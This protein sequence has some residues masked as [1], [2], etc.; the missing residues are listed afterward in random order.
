MVVTTRAKK[1]LLAAAAG[2]LLLFFWLLWPLDFFVRPDTP[3][4]PRLDWAE[5]QTFGE[6]A[7]ATAQQPLEVRFRPGQKHFS[8]FYLYLGRQQAQGGSLVLTVLDA[9]GRE[10]SAQRLE[11]AGLSLPAWQKIPVQGSYKA[12]EE[13]TLRISAGEGSPPIDL[14][15]VADALIPEETLS[16]S[17]PLRYAYD[18]PVFSTAD[19]LLL[20]LC[21][22]GLFGLFAAGLLGEFRG[23]GLLRGAAVFLLL[24]ALAAQNG[25]YGSLDEGNRP[26]FVGFQDNSEALVTGAIAASREPDCPEPG[27]WG[28]YTYNTVEP[29]RTDEEW[30]QGYAR[31]KPAIQLRFSGYT[32][33]VA[34]AGNRVRFANGAELMIEKAEENTQEELI[35]TLQAAGPLS[36]AEY[37][38]LRQAAFV[39]P[40]GEVYPAVS[41]SPYVSQYGLQGRVFVFLSRFIGV[42]N[43]HL[44]CCLALALVFSAI[45]FLIAQRYGPLLAGVF[46]L[47]FLLA[48]KVT[49][50]ARNLY[51]VEFTWFI[52]MAVG[53]F[54]LWKKENAGCRLLSYAAA[55]A[56][57][58]IKSLCGY[59]YLSTIMVA[60]VMFPLAELAVTLS[61][62]QKK[63]AARLFWGTFALGIM[64]LLGFAAALLIHA[65]YRGGGDLWTGVIN[66]YRQDVLRRTVGS[67]SLGLGGAAQASANVSAWQVL[68]MY[69]HVPQQLVT[70]ID[71]NLFPFVCT[72][73]LLIF[74]LDYRA[75]RLELLPLCLYLLSFFAAVSWFVLAKDHS[76]VHVTLNLVLWYFGY[77]QVCLYVILKKFLQLFAKEPLLRQLGIQS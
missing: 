59:E 43:M 32:W 15:T 48:P 37:G 47:T 13:Y 35:L 8:G 26:F 68:C 74:C 9:A 29:Q 54:F 75:K 4:L 63:E 25:L 76:Y 30:D 45:T 7:A 2:A 51:W 70:G 66:I 57:L 77:V 60:L 53:L 49:N 56:A 52:P 61:G 41:I 65:W 33:N 50:F 58:F 44:L 23:R 11:L 67:L 27:R 20:S 62:R 5:G 42:E 6:G 71:G 10:R 34:V 22:A 38:P 31:R 73:P 17:I 14:L 55:F 36:A 40:S 46:Y 19:K 69:F 12:G 28:L 39:N 1:G 21:L 16:G 24:T 18:A 3:A 64:A 72:V